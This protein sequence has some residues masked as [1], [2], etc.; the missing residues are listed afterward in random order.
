VR[1]PYTFASKFCAS[2]SLSSFGPNIT[3]YFT[4]DGRRLALRQIIGILNRMVRHMVSNE[5]RLTLLIGGAL[6]C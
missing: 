1:N 4:Y 6:R 5:H 3:A 2:D